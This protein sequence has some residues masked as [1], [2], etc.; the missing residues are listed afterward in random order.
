VSS[1]LTPYSNSYVGKCLSFLVLKHFIIE[2]IL[3]KKENSSKH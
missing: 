1:F 2:S 3:N